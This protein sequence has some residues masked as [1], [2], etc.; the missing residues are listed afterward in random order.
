MGL[1]SSFVSFGFHRCLVCR[2]FS[3]FHGDGEEKSPPTCAARGPSSVVLAARSGL[4]M[5]AAFD[6]KRLE[7]SSLNVQLARVLHVK[8]FEDSHA[9][10]SKE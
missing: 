2:S 3:P 5:K 8:E 7:S 10:W 4:Q 9:R 6:A 1:S